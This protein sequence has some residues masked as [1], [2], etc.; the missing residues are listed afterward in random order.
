MVDTASSQ[1]VRVVVIGKGL[2]GSAA[3]RHLAQQSAGV[4]LLGPDEPVVR[5][6]HRDVFG[7]HYD[8]GRIYR[9][10]DG[11]PI[12]GRLAE[13]SIARYAVIEAQSGIHF[14]ERVGMLAADL[15]TPPALA[16]AYARTGEELGASFERLA[17]AELAARFPYLRF[18]AATVGLYER[19]TGGHLSPRRMVAA[20]S[21]AAERHG[22]MVVREPVHALTVEPGGVAITTATGR[23][24]RAERALVATGGFANVHAVLPRPL[25]IVVRGRTIVLAEVAGALL[26]R[27]RP[28]P[29]LIVDGSAPLGDP[30]LLPPIEYPDGRWYV[31]LGTGEFEHRLE[32]LD[33]LGEWFR[34]PGA[35]E[36]REALHR[37][38]VALIPD[39]AGA[40][41]HTD[42][43]A[44][45]ATASGYPYVDLLAG[46]RVCVAVGGNGKAAKSAD[47]IGRL[48]AELLLH[49][50]WHDELP[51]EA[52]KAHFRD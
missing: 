38:L 14:H 43:C 19:P 24:V 41:I 46:G 6:D 36:D 10:L 34:S 48:A 22:A 44:V 39:L 49:G 52:F 23:V 5:A 25:D 7:S 37:T 12:W 13:R 2:I 31:K 15:R 51:A 17:S 30:Y 26:E 21:A 32:T 27:L 4:V 18:D 35:A 20:Q 40:P 9:I 8:E 47:E 42:T 11:D 33:E 16:A 1:R 28:M 50:E 3:A 29:S 45:T